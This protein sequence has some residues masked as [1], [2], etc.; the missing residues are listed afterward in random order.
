MVSVNYLQLE[1][2][3]TYAAGKENKNKLFWFFSGVSSQE[4]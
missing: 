2:I 1:Q 3:S 4:L